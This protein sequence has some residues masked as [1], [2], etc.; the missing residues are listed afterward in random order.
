MKFSSQGGVISAISHVVHFLEKRRKLKVS[1]VK[2][3]KGTEAHASMCSVDAQHANRTRRGGIRGD[4]AG[5][6]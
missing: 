2:Y 6:R 1:T 4:T 3:L 5:Y